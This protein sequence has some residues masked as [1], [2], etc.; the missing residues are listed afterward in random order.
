M[1]KHWEDMDHWDTPRSGRWSR[2]APWMVATAAVCFALGL[3]CGSMWIPRTVSLDNRE[4]AGAYPE[5]NPSI[6]SG[7]NNAL[8]PALSGNTVSQIY[9]MA[10]P[11]VVTITAVANSDTSNKNNPA[12]DIGTGFFIDDQGDIATNNHVVNGQTTVSISL[13]NHSYKGKVIGTDALDDLA[14][15]RITP[16]PSGIKP[17]S[18]GTAKTLQPGD[19]VVA[20]GNPFELTASVSAGIVS[21]LNRSMPTDSGR[22]MSGLVQTDAALNPGNSGG[23]LLNASGQVVG[24]NTAIES[25]VEGSVGIG[26]AVPIDRL[27]KVLPKLLS[28]TPVDHPWLGIIGLD[29]TPALVQKYHLPVNQ[30]VLVI[31]TSPG[32]P[33]SKAGLRGDSGGQN[34]PVG[35]GDIITAVN[36]QPVADIE[37]L[38]AYISNQ[39]VGDV[40]HLS[41]LRHGRSMDVAAT[42]QAWPSNLKK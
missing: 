19:L 41:V 37:S 36:G 4:S 32:G 38:T 17:L 12:E 42:L 27:E 21:G 35:D 34:N 29:I 16:P 20:I 31:G 28:G 24:I 10:R 23:P 30:G 40:V 15:V 3:V 5:S 25:P 2:F 13:D 18:L 7:Q 33:A 39:N 14:V 6:A 22:L 8:P 11:S 1:A 9:Q 26:F